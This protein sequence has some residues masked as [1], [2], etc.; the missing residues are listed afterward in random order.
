MPNVTVSSDIHDF[1]QAEDNFAARNSLEIGHCYVN[2]GSFTTNAAN[3]VNVTNLAYPIQSGE[4]VYIEVQG[5]QNGGA[6]GEGMKIA[7]T[8]PNN[9]TYVRYGFEHYRSL[10]QPGIASTATGFGTVL[11]DLAGFAENTPFRSNLILINGDNTGTVQ[12]QATS[13]TTNTS[14]TISGAIMR[15]TK[16]P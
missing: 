13:E 7:F 4:G 6:A 9:P 3:P 8:G 5:F 15:V 14:L 16:I 1:M 12:F 10:T 2:T 11:S